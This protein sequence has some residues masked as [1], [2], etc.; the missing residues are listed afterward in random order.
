M[1]LLCLLSLLTFFALPQLHT[2][3]LQEVRTH[4]VFEVG[5]AQRLQVRLDDARASVN[6]R[7]TYS[8]VVVVEIII[9]SQ[10]KTQ[11]ELQEIARTE[12]FN[13]QIQPN[14]EKNLLLLTPSAQRKNTALFPA[15]TSDLQIIYNIAVP[16]YVAF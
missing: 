12:M 1:Q 2:Q 14:G 4:Q 10:Q 13:L 5:Q 7:E 9:Q 6:L 15:T 8:S 3:P 11:R 16:E